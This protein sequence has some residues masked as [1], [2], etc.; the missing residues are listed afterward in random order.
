LNFLGLS[1][2][3]DPTLTKKAPMISND[4]NVVSSDQEQA[5]IARG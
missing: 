5:D 1:F 2:D 4:P 3:N